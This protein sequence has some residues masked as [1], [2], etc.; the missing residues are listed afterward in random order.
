MK[1]MKTTNALKTISLG[2][3]LVMSALILTKCTKNNENASALDRRLAGTDSTVFAQFYDSTTIAT[4][5][6][7]PGINDVIRTTGVQSIIQNRCA[8]ANCH[9][10][11]I[12]P[13][14]NTYEQ[15]KSLTTPG[16]PEGSELFSRITTNDFHDAMPPVYVG[17]LTTSEKVIIY[18]W[19]KNGSKEKPALEDFRPSAIHLIGSGCSSSGC[20]DE[21]TATGAWARAKYFSIT[22]GDTTTFISEGRPFAILKKSV[23]DPIWTAY[24]D[25][26]KKFYADTLANA[27]FRPYKIFSSPTGVA[28]SAVVASTRGPLNTY[29][30]IIMDIWYPK[31]VRSVSGTT[32]VYT[33]G[34]G[35]KYFVRGN[36]LNSNDCFI[37]RIDS[38]IIYTN[39]VTSV[40]Q[41]VNGS[42]ARSDGHW[43]PS[44]IAI[45]KAW[46]FAD[47][48][49]PD[50]WKYGASN[51]GIFKFKSGKVI[52]K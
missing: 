34:G 35:K 25:S 18:N 21:Q 41:S 45:V 30:D 17:E 5:D 33:D 27:S 52:T 16:N 38:T 26:V 46:Y 3:L 19:I 48:N 47:T 51:Q 40:A 7:V 49:I 8:T 22:A 24:K 36:Y 2:L 10:G 42:M 12:E 50:V 15:I 9:G 44:E 23:S 6:V 11:A 39:Q 32:P 28:S 31:S 13:K 43:L 1:N 37:R 4:A 29:D 14:L 20:H